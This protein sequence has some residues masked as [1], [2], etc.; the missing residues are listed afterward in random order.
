MC[1]LEKTGILDL[2]ND[3]ASL[4]SNWRFG[5]TQLTRCFLAWNRQSKFHPTHQSRRWAREEAMKLWYIHRRLDEA[6]EDMDTWTKLV[7][8]TE[9]SSPAKQ[10]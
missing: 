4:N 7:V 10:R 5:G 3:M 2:A 8:D 1:S 6:A 9:I